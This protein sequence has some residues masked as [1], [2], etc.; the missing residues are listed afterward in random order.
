MLFRVRGKGTFVVNSSAGAAKCDLVG[1][2]LSDIINPNFA[3]L[4][5]T[6]QVLAHD[7]GYS[8]LLH[9][10]Y[11][12]P[13]RLKHIVDVYRQKNVCATIIHGSAVRRPQYFEILRQSRIPI[14]GAETKI[15]EID[16]VW[17]DMES[18]SH[19]L[20][21]HLLDRFGPSIAYISGSDDPI[22]KTSRF[23]GYRSALAGKGLSV[24]LRLLK[25]TQPTYV[26]GYKIIQEMLDKKLL[27]RSVMFYN[28][29]MA[30][31]ATSALLGG[32]V[33]IPDDIAIAAFDDSIDV[34][35]MVIPTTT[36]A[37]S[38]TEMAHQLLRLVKRRLSNPAKRPESIRITPKLIMRHSTEI[39]PT[40]ETMHSISA[41][42]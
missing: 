8:I 42:A 11:N 19:I 10:A 23:L 20:T 6:I 5:Q 12:Q 40:S 39:A 17:P 1:L 16:D 2:L 41:G 34:N 14:I 4:A 21:E 15:T 35:Q 32:N 24:D 33:I 30:M 29:I 9:T 13:Q 36:L 28:L 7:Y 27:P 26:G 25:Q 18:G 31:G 3:Q 22:R 38:N 37:F